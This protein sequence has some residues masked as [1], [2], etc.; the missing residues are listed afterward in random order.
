MNEKQ[1]Q[2]TRVV[3]NY[4]WLSAGA[5][6]IPIPYVDWATVTGVQVKMLA[7]VSKIYAVPYRRNVGKAA[8]TSMVGFILPHAMAFGLLGSLTKAIPGLGTLAGAPAM[9]I[10]CGAYSWALG[11]VFIQHFESGGTFLNFNPE[12]VKEY[13]KAKFEEGRYMDASPTVTNAAAGTV[14]VQI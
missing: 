8:V 6:L 4:R 12:E 14:E 3:N 10:F 1:L 11:N 7:E 5:S 9:A 2:A 13:F